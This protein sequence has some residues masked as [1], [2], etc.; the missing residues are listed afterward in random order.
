MLCLFEWYLKLLRSTFGVLG[1][2]RDSF[3][4]INVTV[5]GMNQKHCALLQ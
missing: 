1:H 4:L 3:M 5:L 2:M